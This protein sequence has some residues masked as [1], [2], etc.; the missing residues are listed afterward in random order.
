MPVFTGDRVR[1][2]AE[3]IRSTLNLAGSLTDTATHLHYG[4]ADPGSAD[5]NHTLHPSGIPLL[6]AVKDVLESIEPV[7]QVLIDE[8]EVRVQDWIDN[9]PPF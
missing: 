6:Q 5:S 1:D 2:A 7:L 3:H 8:L 4:A 9:P